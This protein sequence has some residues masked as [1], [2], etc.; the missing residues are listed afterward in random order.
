M[1]EK[2]DILNR[3]ERLRAEIDRHNKLYYV[4]DNPEISDTEYDSLM[5][6]LQTL[7]RD[8]PQFRSPDSPTQRVGAEPVA[9]FGIVEHPR[10]LLSLGNVF[11]DEELDAWFTRT[12][13]LIGD[14]PFNFVCEHKIDGLAVALTYENGRLVTGATRGD[15]I[16]GENITKNLR[17]I[18]SIPLT[19]P[20]GAPSL[21]EVR[22]EV[23]LPKE[24]FH[25][26]NQERED[27]G[28][29]L[30]ANPRNAAA[31]SLRQLDSRITARRPLN[32]FLYMLGRIEGAEPP[33]THSETLLWL[34][35]EF[36][37]RINPYTRQVDTLEEVK[38]FYRETVENRDSL[39]Y[40]AD[41]MVV[42]LNQIALQEELGDVG[43]EPRWAV[44]YK[45]PAIQATTKLLDIAINVGRTGTM[46]P[47]ARLE[48][49]SVGGVTISNAALHNEEDIH[50]K[51]IRINDTVIIQRAGDVIPEVI[52]PTPASRERPDRNEPFN[53]LE[54]LPKNDKGQ[55]SCPE[56]GH[57]IIQPE[58]EV[59]YYCSNAACPAQAVQ[60]IGLFASRGA[61][62]IDGLGEKK[63]PPLYKLGI[64]R[65]VSDLYF[66]NTA[67]LTGAKKLADDI[68]DDLANKLKLAID[69]ALIPIKK[70][71]TP[72]GLF[73]KLTNEPF[74]EKQ[75][76]SL[77]KTYNL[78]PS[79]VEFLQKKTK[80]LIAEHLP[81]LLQD[82][83]VNQDLGWADI[84]TL[85][86]FG[87]KNVEEL[88][89]QIEHSKKRPLARIGYGLGIKHVGEETANLLTGR[90]RSI[91]SLAEASRED[92]LNV[93]SIGPK[94]ADAILAF[95]EQDSNRD[96]IA[97]LKQAGVFPE[98]EEEGQPA[99]D[100]PLSG[101]EFVL[102]GKLESF[103]RPEAEEKIKTLGGSAKSS[104]TRKTSYVVV[105]EDPGSKAEKAK[106]LGIA[107]LNESEFLELLRT[108]GA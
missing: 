13:K 68:I 103:S 77:F 69:E 105:G 58:G 89:K 50:R 1:A 39:A 52:G 63:I 10:P 55:P 76:E 65:D 43:R 56:C 100:R 35:N 95:F 42:K 38:T 83:Q 45:F 7:E 72:T 70:T 31:G 82:R 18:K 66:L 32:I 21:L 8:Y 41:G 57:E 73:K 93:P 3:I 4:H 33:E 54:T 92:L 28:L 101:K 87:P 98:P 90:F 27:E 47:I 102:T 64:L 67:S 60:R 78:I 104:V 99:G 48:P 96:I 44:A 14:R 6:E 9:A 17:T 106:Q 79:Q 97:R 11:S 36:G 53:L 61:M 19:L 88:L 26:L 51:D 29:P 49:V 5:R 107:I 23:Y 108:S 71:L 24:G 46:N 34:K 59:M 80:E 75:T 37:F 94:I 74:T 85:E 86:M 12:R 62:D 40:E 20:D 25:K 30:F 84:R 91:E 16:R 22:G 81:D 15:G 2:D